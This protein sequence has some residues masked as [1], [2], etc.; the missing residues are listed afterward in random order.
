MHAAENQRHNKEAIHHSEIVN[1]LSGAN[2]L[3]KN[4]MLKTERNF[5]FNVQQSPNCHVSHYGGS[6]SRKPSSTLAALTITHSPWL[7][8]DQFHRL[9]LKPAE[10]Q[11]EPQLAVALGAEKCEL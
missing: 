5:R 3:S 4:E 1:K 10:R 2:K 11:I 6:I 9:H 7:L 8:Q